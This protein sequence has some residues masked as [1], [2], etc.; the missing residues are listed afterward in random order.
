MVLEVTG[1]GEACLEDLII[2][3]SSGNALDATVEDCTTISVGGGDIA[4]CTDMEACNYDPDATV[5]DLSL[6]H[7]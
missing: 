5:D 2:S 6:I 3:D 1:S 7:I 4:G